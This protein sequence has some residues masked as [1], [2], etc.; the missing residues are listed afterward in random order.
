MSSIECFSAFYS[1]LTFSVRS[2]SSQSLIHFLFS[3]QSTSS[4]QSFPIDPETEKLRSELDHLLNP[5]VKNHYSDG[6]C[7]VYALVD[8]IYPEPE[9]V[10][11]VADEVEE[12][13]EKLEEEK[14]EEKMVV[15]TPI[16]KA[17]TA[18]VV[19]VSEEEEIVTEALPTAE[20]EAE[21]ESIVVDE[22][23]KEKVEEKEEEAAVVEEE[24]IIPEAKVPKVLK[25]PT[26]HPI[27]SRIF[28]LYLVGNKYNPTNF[29]FV[30]SLFFV[31]RRVVWLLIFVSSYDYD[32]DFDR[33]GRWKAFYKVNY[34]LNT[35]VG[36]VQINCHYY[37]QGK[38]FPSSLLFPPTNSLSYPG[39]VQLATTLS[40]TTTFPSNATPTQ[41]LSLI[42]QME[43]KSQIKISEIYV[44][45]AEDSFKGLRRALPKTRSKIDWEK[46]SGYRLGGELGGGTKA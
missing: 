46:I 18:E 21:P 9:E 33:T 15:D 1:S 39:N 19:G 2:L 40:S 11:E 29:W 26:I 8:E 43:N 31:F 34:H 3:K 37:E 20:V 42:K 4:P 6:V 5:Y 17:T 14:E 44:N 13:Q 36:T 10:E 22:P 23:E 45:L 30:L 12:E 32:Y 38:Y 41:I 28:G 16:L 27:Q 7:S 24:P 25:E 35:L